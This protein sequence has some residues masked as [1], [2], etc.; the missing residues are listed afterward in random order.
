MKPSPI[1]LI[2][3]YVCLASVILWVVDS[4]TATA[5]S[6]SASC[7]GGAKVTCQAYRCV[8]QDNVGCTGYDAQGRVVSDSPCPARMP[9]Q[10]APVE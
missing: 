1:S 5:A 10:E 8:C 9:L 6:G 4:T 2:V 7:G 3:R